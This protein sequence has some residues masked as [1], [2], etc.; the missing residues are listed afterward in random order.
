MNSSAT[1][2]T[3]SKAKRTLRALVKSHHSGSSRQKEG[4]STTGSHNECGDGDRRTDGDT[5]RF[6]PYFGTTA[7]TPE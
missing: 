1:A 4:C 3:Q 5:K 7:S 2:G 6:G